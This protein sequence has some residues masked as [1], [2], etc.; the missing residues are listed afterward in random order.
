[1][2]C[3][4]PTGLFLW[5]DASKAKGKGITQA[6]AASKSRIGFKGSVSKTAAVT[7][8]HWSA[9]QRDAALPPPGEHFTSEP[10][11]AASHQLGRRTPKAQR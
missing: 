7:P 3:R 10:P 8:G 9:V 2:P 4:Q 11:G 1:M 6:T 5:T